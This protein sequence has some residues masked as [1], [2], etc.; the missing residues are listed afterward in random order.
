ME[1]VGEMNLRRINSKRKANTAAP[2]SAKKRKHK[3]T[4]VGCQSAFVTISKLNRHAKKCTTVT[5]A[6]RE[7]KEKAAPEQAALAAQKKAARE[8]KEKAAREKAALAAQKKVAR[9]AK[10]KVGC[11]GTG[12]SDARCAAWAAGT[13]HM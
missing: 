11:C 8:A 9:E 10:E 12:E 1:A 2:A 5:V 13:P 4:V 3:C 6:A 7:A